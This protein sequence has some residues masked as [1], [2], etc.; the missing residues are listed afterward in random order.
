MPKV[1]PSL[2]IVLIA[3]LFVGG[4]AYGFLGGDLAP[5]NSYSFDSFNIGQ[6]SE[7]LKTDSLVTFKK[8]TLPPEKTSLNP[9]GI[10]VIEP[11]INSN[12]NTVKRYLIFG[13]GSIDNVDKTSNSLLRELTQKMEFF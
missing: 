11:I 2:I 8:N 6:N 4:N 5:Q 9:T 1:A 10:L 12:Q 13:S 3:S 7:I